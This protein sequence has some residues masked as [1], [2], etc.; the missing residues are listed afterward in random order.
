MPGHLRCFVAIAALLGSTFTSAL[1]A[2]SPGG[3]PSLKALEVEEDFEQIRGKMDA[4]KVTADRMVR[5]RR[6]ACLRAFGMIAFCDCLGEELPMA[7]SFEM[8][9]GVV[10][11]TKERLGYQRLGNEDRA[12][13]D[14]LFLAREK[15]VGRVFA[16]ASSQLDGMHPRPMPP[17]GTKSAVDRPDEPAANP[18]GR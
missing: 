8:Y 12:I 2:D 3:P 15:C 11:K 18:A 16:P 6:L 10:T 4:L 1:P 5:Q 14:G 13:A 9:I 17:H 7:A